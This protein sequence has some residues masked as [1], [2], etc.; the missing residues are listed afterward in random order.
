VALPRVA[1]NLLLFFYFSV[2]LCASSGKIY[3]F[4]LSLKF[5]QGGWRA[6]VLQI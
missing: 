5:W 1:R 6:W 2:I 3:Q 4:A